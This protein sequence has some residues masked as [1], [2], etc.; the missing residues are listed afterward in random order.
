MA[1]YFLTT[2]PNKLLVAFK[3]A[4]DDG[5]VVT[6]SYDSDGDFTHT[7]PQWK[8]LAWFHPSVQS[9]RLVL[10][11]I[12]PQNAN[13]TTEVYAIYHGRIIE[14]MLV[15]C[16]TIFTKGVATGQPESGDVVE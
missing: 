15:H 1:V 8:D 12:K 4:I 16:D 7:A 3:K 14:S 6:W 9:D 11:I 2:T 10:N 13:M 5:H